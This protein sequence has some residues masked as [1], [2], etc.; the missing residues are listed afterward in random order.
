TRA[1]DGVLRGQAREGDHLLEGRGPGGRRGLSGLRAAVVHRD[2]RA[3]GGAG[4][5]RSEAE[6]LVA[7]LDLGPVHFQPAQAALR[8]A[9][10]LLDQRLLADEILLL[11]VDE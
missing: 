3:R 11:E 10:I 9:A 6:R 5:G 7:L 4:D 2:G 8:S 1:L